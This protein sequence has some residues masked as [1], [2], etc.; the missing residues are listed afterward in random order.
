MVDGENG[1]H[2]EGEVDRAHNDGLEERGVGG[3]AHAFEDVSGVVEDY[4]DADKLLEDGQHDA[5]EDDEHSKGQH[6]SGVMLAERGADFREFL[7]ALLFCDQLGQDGAGT[8]FI[9]F[10]HE[11]AWR[12]RDKEEQEQYVMEGLSVSRHN[13]P[14]IAVWVTPFLI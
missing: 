2:R 5:D 14:T 4:I 8:G 6:F 7:F 3:E 12:F 9:A 13:T 1:Y 10:E 11:V